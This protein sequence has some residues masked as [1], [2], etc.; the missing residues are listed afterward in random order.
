MADHL[1]NGLLKLEAYQLAAHLVSDRA[2]IRLNRFYLHH[3]GS[4]DVITF[5]HGELV[6]K[7]YTYGEIYICIDEAVRQSS[8]FRTLWP[9]EVM[10]YLTHG[11]LH[12]LDYDDQTSADRQVMKRKENQLLR[13]LKKV[14]LPESI[15]ETLPA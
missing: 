3:A 15:G 5:D 12:L 2:M 11:M 7:R 9:E 1:L 13:E 10:R 8:R 6:E 14:H 4:T